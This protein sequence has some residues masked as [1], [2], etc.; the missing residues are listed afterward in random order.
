M[1]DVGLS[2]DLAVIDA[3]A[4]SAMLIDEA[5]LKK[6]GLRF[7]YTKKH[8]TKLSIFLLVE[9]ILEGICIIFLILNGIFLI[10]LG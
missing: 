8:L 1:E 3:I 6:K 2:P 4:S 10:T 5:E 7:N 9:T